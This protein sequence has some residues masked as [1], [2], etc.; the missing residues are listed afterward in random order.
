MRSVVPSSPY[1]LGKLID[2]K[3]DDDFEIG[4]QAYRQV[5]L[6]A[7]EINWL[8]TSLDALVCWY[9]DTCSLLA[10]EINW[11]ETSNSKTFSNKPIWTSSPYSLGKLI[12]W[13]LLELQFDDLDTG[14]VSLLARE[15]NWLETVD[16]LTWF[17]SFNACSLLAREI[18]WLE[19]FSTNPTTETVTG[20]L[21]TR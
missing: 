15:I 7:R 6:L 14:F 16:N 21:P 19:T 3:R 13:K 10:R 18:N 9:W 20:L 1:S 12:D 2:W 4:S 5:S 17:Q 11:L 8:E